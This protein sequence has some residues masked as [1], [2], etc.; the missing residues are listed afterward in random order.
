MIVRAGGLDSIRVRSRTSSCD[1]RRWRCAH[2]PSARIP[3]VPHGAADSRSRWCSISSASERR[4]IPS[5]HRDVSVSLFA[6][7]ER[8]RAS[9]S[10]ATCA[11]TMWITIV[12]DQPTGGRY[13]PGARGLLGRRA[14]AGFRPPMMNIP[15]L[16]NFADQVFP[17]ESLLHERRVGDR[18]RN[19]TFCESISGAAS[20]ISEPDVNGSMYLD[21]VNFQ[22]RRSVLRLTK[23]PEE[24][25]RTSRDARR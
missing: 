23:I 6:S 11:W 16:V 19:R 1:S 10:T 13:K 25:C 18:R 24:L 2:I 5:A 17:R 9:L 8:C 7:S 22:I 14:D 21:P 15:T 3:A 20:R 4:S 12:R